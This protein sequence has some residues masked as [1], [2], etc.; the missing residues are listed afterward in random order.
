MYLAR[1]VYLVHE[2]DRFVVVS[3]ADIYPV[4]LKDAALAFQAVPG[5]GIQT[6]GLRDAKDSAEKIKGM[7]LAVAGKDL[8][9]QPRFWQS[10][11]HQN[12]ETIRQR[13]K[14]LETLRTRSDQARVIVDQWLDKQSGRAE[15]YLAFPLVSR[16]H[17][18]TV[19]LDKDLNMVGYLPIDPF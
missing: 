1:P 18:W 5:L 7:E 19:V 11:S 6:I 12:R 3:A 14:P 15:V 4:D 10:L 16:E 2:V 9:L 13:A 8:S 17:Y